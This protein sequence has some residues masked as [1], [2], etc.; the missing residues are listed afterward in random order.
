MMMTAENISKPQQT[1]ANSRYFFLGMASVVLC[2][3]MFMSVFTPVPLTFA[4]IL[5]GRVR[6][7]LLASLGLVVTA[8]LSQ[9]IFPKEVLI[10]FYLVGFLIS[11]AASEIWFRKISPYKGM[12]VTGTLLLALLGAGMGIGISQLKK[13]VSSYIVEE[14]QKISKELNTEREKIIQEGGDE[15][16]AMIKF[17][18]NP[19]AVVQEVIYNFPTFMFIAVFFGLWINLLVVI[20]SQRMLPLE[21][22]YPY[23]EKDFLNFTMPDW[24][25]FIL[26]PALVLAVWGKEYFGPVYELVGFSILKCLGLFYFFQGYGVFSGLLD[27]LNIGGFIRSFMVLFTILTASWIIA[28]IGLFD[29]WVNFKKWFIRKNNNNEGDDL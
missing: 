28:L 3:S 6:G 21:E 7:Y 24:S 9:W 25:I 5:Y 26:I 18:N 17:F 1:K 4:H 13:P 29:N 10:V 19:E 11:I 8:V 23:N 12:V 27:F 16:L 2:L 15:S 22:V 14:V 20:R